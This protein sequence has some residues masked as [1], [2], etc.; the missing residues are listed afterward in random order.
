MRVGTKVL[1]VIAFLW[2]ILGIV[3]TWFVFKNTQ[4]LA[5]AA[6]S[7]GSLTAL[8]LLGATLALLLQ[9]V[10][11][12]DQQ[13]KHLENLRAEWQATQE[14]LKQLL[15]QR[16]QLGVLVQL[17]HHFILSAS[18]Q[19]V[20][21]ALLR[22]LP[23]FLRLSEMEIV[24]FNANPVYGIWDRLTNEMTVKELENQDEGSLP[25]W[26]RGQSLRGMEQIKDALIV[27]I[28]TDESI[29]ALMKLSRELDNPF[30]NDEMRFLE[31]VANQTALALERVRLI[32]FLENLSLT[33]SLTGIA[34]RRHFEWRLSEEVERA[35]RY[36]YPLTVLMLDL[37]NF[38]QINDTHG[39]II[40]DIVLQQIAQRLR[41]ALRRTDFLARYG[42]E[43]FV[44][45]APQT[46][47]DRALILAER[48]RR[49]I[50]ESLI[51]VADNLS[52]HVTISI[53][54]AVF[55]EHAQNESELVHA[56]DAALYKAK[57]LGRNKVCLFEPEPVKGGEK[58]VRA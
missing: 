54:V 41:G 3:S 34:N 8:A 52:L 36:R 11:A 12:V 5:L 35:R 33:D 53:G 7:A 16:D 17:L 13:Q 42:G 39:H 18:R 25:Q 1:V 51:Q 10:S 46:P 44:I 23:Y 27:P 9:K 2:L 32:A 56:A 38:K 37:D 45:L 14:S 43:E 57:Q 28:V 24:V 29:I 20:V 48:L 58:D 50:A 22:E 30:K 6:F 21:L 15:N 31:A 26:A 40:G 47:V 55:P 4:N 19:D 49:T